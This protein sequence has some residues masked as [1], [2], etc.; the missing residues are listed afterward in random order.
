MP[1]LRRPV[2]FS[3]ETLISATRGSEAGTKTFVKEEAKLVLRQ[4]CSVYSMWWI[5]L[6]LQN[7]ET[8]LMNK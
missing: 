1:E 7:A 6:C 5:K 2:E 8:K 3:E 4:P